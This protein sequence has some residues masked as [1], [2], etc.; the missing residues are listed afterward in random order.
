MFSGTLDTTGVQ[1][2]PANPNKD[3]N[4]HIFIQK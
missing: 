2:M 3:N 4:K 1:L